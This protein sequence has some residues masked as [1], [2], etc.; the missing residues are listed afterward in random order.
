MNKSFVI[1][2]GFYE[3]HGFSIICTFDVNNTTIG[4]DF[5]FRLKAEGCKAEGCKAEG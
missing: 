4:G 1:L 2:K 5:F 3:A